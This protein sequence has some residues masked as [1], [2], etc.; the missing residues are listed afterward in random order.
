M[1]KRGETKMD[2]MDDCSQTE[3]LLSFAIAVTKILRSETELRITGKPLAG[4]PARAV[5]RKVVGKVP[6][7]TGNN[8]LATHP[9]PL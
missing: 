7:M 8:S 3:K 6:S 4:K 9:T 2:T 5:W 1:V